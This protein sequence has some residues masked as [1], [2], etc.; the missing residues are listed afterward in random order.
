VPKFVVYQVSLNSVNRL[1]EKL[2]C[3]DCGASDTGGLLF[4]V[5]GTE[6]EAPTA[7]SYFV[8]CEMQ[9]C[10]Q[11]LICMILVSKSLVLQ[12]SGNHC[13]FFSAKFTNQHSLI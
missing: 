11:K 9:Q 6:T 2:E 1:L 10:H 4:G 12:M 3:R 13:K 7:I 5:F 8:F